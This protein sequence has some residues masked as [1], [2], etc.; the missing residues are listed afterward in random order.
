MKK[1]LPQAIIALAV[2]LVVG[3]AYMTYR[4]IKGGDS[5]EI[6]EEESIPELP[7][8]QR[9]FVSLVPSEDGH[10]LALTIKDINVDGAATVDFELL[11]IRGDGLQQGTSGVSDVSPGTTVTDDLL[12]GSESSGKLRYDEGVET[13]TLEL[14]FRDESGKSIGRLITEFHLQS[15]T[16]S[17][18]S[19]DGSFTKELDVDGEGLFFVTMDT[20]KG[21]KVFSS[22]G[23]TY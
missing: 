4:F 15:D 19:V 17:V 22:D 5:T 11:Y 6:E 23:E 3:G 20:F 16:T 12:L 13:G 14:I 2:L 21:Y 9:P 10:W 18:S 8:S 7:E 1:Y